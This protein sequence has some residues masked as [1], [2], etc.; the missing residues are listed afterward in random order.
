MAVRV[1]LAAERRE[2]THPESHRNHFGSKHSECNTNPNAPIPL[3]SPKAT[4]SIEGLTAR[5]DLLY[6]GV[7]LCDW[8]S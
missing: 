5:Q 8:N 6:Y 7:T 1:D 4:A 2:Y 3:A